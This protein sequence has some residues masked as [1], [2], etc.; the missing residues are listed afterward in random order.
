MKILVVTVTY[1]GLKW[2][3]RCAGSVYASGTPADFYVVD[4]ASSDGTADYIEENF[5]QAILVRS[6][7]NLG[8]GKANNLG[9]K[10]AL[11]NGYDYV[12][13]LNQDAWLLPDTLGGL[14]EASVS[15]PGFY[16]LSPLQMRG[17]ER[18]MDP[19]F[20]RRVVPYVQS[21]GDS[22]GVVPYVM[23]AHWLLTRSCIE[24]VGLLAPIFPIYGEDDNYCDRVRYHGGKVGVVS[25]A[26]AVHD[27]AMRQEPLEKT[28]HRNYYMNSL[29]MLCDINHPLSC[30][31]IYVCIFT[32]VKAFK[33]RSLLP[34][35]HFRELCRLLPSIRATRSA[36]RQPGAFIN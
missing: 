16:V 11:E 4:N 29:R 19:N 9:L 23:A 8:F 12:Y 32:A 13:L 31:F 28:I 27:R 10:Y 22:P 20:E 35:R 1:N 2:I 3:G 34:F 18:G 25:S 6:K 7:E 26:K 24:K 14:V 30:R 5:P 17:D 21:P 33:Y 15:N 36:T